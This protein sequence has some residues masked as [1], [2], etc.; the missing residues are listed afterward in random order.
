MLKY[1]KSGIKLNSCNIS[2]EVPKVSPNLQNM[3][4]YT[5]SCWALNRSFL[6]EGPNPWFCPSLKDFTDNS[7]EHENNNNNDTPSIPKRLS[8]LSKNL[9][10]KWLSGLFVRSKLWGSKLDI[11]APNFHHQEIFRHRNFGEHFI[12]VIFFTLRAIMTTTQSTRVVNNVIT[13]SCGV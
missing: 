4:Q 8:Y 3:L 12:V 7:N 6:K 9:V 10:P 11:S 13:T 2:K 1:T 5:T